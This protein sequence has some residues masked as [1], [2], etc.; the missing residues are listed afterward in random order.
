MRM[1]R[2]PTPGSDNGNWGT[3]LNDYLTQVHN[4]DGTLKA[5]IV[6]AAEIVDGSVTEAQLTPSVQNK[7]NTAGSGNVADGTITTAK[8]NDGAVTAAFSAI[9]S[10]SVGTTQFFAAS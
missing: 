9:A 2:L 4:N 1:A 8:L 5:N 6:T 7:P 10:A 3:I